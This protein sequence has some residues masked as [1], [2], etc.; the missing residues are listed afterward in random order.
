[1]PAD[2]CWSANTGWADFNQ[3]ATIVAKDADELKQ[4]LQAFSDGEAASAAG[5]KQGTAR[6]IG[7]PGVAF[8]FTGQGSQ[9]VGM[10]RGLYE[11]QPVFRR[12][13]D[14]CDAIL[15]ECWGG[16]SLLSILYPNPQANGSVD[17]AKVNQTQYTQPALFSI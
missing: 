16:E 4:R 13:I 6:S 5:L 8:L 7:R 3:R 11:T 12:A 9:Y 15:R 2:V 10:G 14:N 1:S 17:G